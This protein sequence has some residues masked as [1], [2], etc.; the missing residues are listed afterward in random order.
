ME[1]RQGVV[2]QFSPCR[3]EAERVIRAARGEMSAL[4]VTNRI[5]P[6]ASELLE[7]KPGLSS[8]RGFELSFTPLHSTPVSCLQGTET[9]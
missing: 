3:E 5:N 6:S 8:C 2:Y 4:R 9:D 1:A 7:G